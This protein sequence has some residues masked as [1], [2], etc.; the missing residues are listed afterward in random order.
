[1]EDVEHAIE[2]F[3]NAACE[4]YARQYIVK[5]YKLVEIPYVN[6]KPST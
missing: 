1:V 6:S 4:E 2:Q 3:E 5:I